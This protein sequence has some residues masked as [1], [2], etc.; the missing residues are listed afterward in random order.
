MVSATRKF[1]ID[2]RETSLELAKVEPRMDIALSDSKDLLAQMPHGSLPQCGLEA[3]PA[4]IAGFHKLWDA[5]R[6]SVR[7]YL[8][9]IVANKSDVEDCVQEV[10]LIAWKKGPVAEGERAFLGH[11]LATARLI[12]LSTSRKIGNSKVRFL[13]PD[14]AVSLADEVMRQ[15]Q[16]E[17]GP[18]ERILALRACM[19]Q[20]DTGQREL[21][22]LRYAEDSQSRLDHFAKTE[23]M[24]TNAL[25]KKLERLRS[26][27]REC[28][29]RRLKGGGDH[30]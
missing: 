26:G 30:A 22:S 1:R 19:E 3:E 2:P 6:V 21:L 7:A 16:E 27:L 13:P 17:D 20:L 9:S 15:E 4:R 14:L 24:K 12:G 18:N 29:T 10:A 8:S 25:Y 5:C 23:G 11:C 28:V